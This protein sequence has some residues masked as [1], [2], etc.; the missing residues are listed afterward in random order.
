MVM[1]TGRCAFT[2]N[3][4]VKVSLQKHTDNFSLQYWNGIEP[5]QITY[6]EL[7]YRVASERILLL[8]TVRVTIFEVTIFLHMFW[9]FFRIWQFINIRGASN[10]IIRKIV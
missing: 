4:V 8:I 7:A 3:Q 9:K 10:L 1:I 6:F 5:Y 2:D